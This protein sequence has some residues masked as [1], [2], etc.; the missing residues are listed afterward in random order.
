[1]HGMRF[2]FCCFYS[3]KDNNEKMFSSEGVLFQK[4]INDNIKKNYF[5]LGINLLSLNFY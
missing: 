3:I 1:M 4:F 5:K 2:I